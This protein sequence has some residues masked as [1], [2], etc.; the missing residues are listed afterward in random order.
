MYNLIFIFTKINDAFGEILYNHFISI[1]IIYN[2]FTNNLQQHFPILS[3][4]IEK[5]NY[6]YRRLKT[7]IMEETIDP[8]TNNWINMSVLAIKKTQIKRDICSFK[9]HKYDIYENL[10][11]DPVY[12]NEINAPTCIKKIT[13]IEKFNMYKTNAYKYINSSSNKIDDI[14]VNEIVEI[15]VT[16]NYENKLFH[17]TIPLNNTGNDDNIISITE[18]SKVRFVCIEYHHPEMKTSPLLLKIPLN[19]FYVGNHILGSL[20]VKRILENQFQNYIFD[21]DYYLNVIDMDFNKF[22]LTIG[23][24]II[25]DKFDYTP[26]LI[27]N[28]H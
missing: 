17:Y 21:G 7:Y 3:I 11:I 10:F 9:I 26:F 19:S 20:F 8:Q 25:I 28:A 14:M 5:L 27:Q 15:M 4:Y 13:A 22:R 23:E 1:F 12:G 6:N 16:M 24:F 2:H 18:P